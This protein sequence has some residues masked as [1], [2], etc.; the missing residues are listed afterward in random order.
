MGE[1]TFALGKE[2]ALIVVDVQRD[3]CEGGSLAVPGSG[4]VIPEINKW[5]RQFYHSSFPI[6]ATKDWHP[7]LT[8]HFD[9]WPAHCVMGTEGAKFHPELDYVYVDKVFFKGMGQEPGYS[10]FE[11]KNTKGQDLE[12]VLGSVGVKRLWIVGIATDYCVKTTAID[13]AKR[14]FETHVVLP[15]CAGVDEEG[16]RQAIEDMR[17]Y[18]VILDEYSALDFPAELESATSREQGSN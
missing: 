1:P 2:N 3:F 12:L 17:Q 18:G 13:A 4:V 8:P 10:G 5:I 15:A 11:G 7:K 14:G 6:Y 9:A 16:T